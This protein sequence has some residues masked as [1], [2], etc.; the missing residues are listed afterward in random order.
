MTRM[1]SAVYFCFI[2]FLYKRFKIA[3]FFACGAQLGL[4]GALLPLLAAWTP[5]DNYGHLGT[6]MDTHAYGPKFLR[7]RRTLK[8]FRACGAP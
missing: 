8:V 7:L 2:K 5:M 1:M 4:G 6:P 3:I